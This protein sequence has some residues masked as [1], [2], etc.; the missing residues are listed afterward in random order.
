MEKVKETLTTVAKQHNLDNTVVE[1]LNDA[2]EQLQV[3]VQDQVQAAQ[4]TLSGS[5][6]EV[7]AK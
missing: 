7:S 1:P 2:L 4:K 6:T 3:R 5:T